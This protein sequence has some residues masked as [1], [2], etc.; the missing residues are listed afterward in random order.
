MTLHP[1]QRFI[2]GVAFTLIAASALA[3][4]TRVTGLVSD[5]ATGEPLPFV[6]VAFVDSRIAT[7][8]DID[9]QYAFDTYYATD[10]LRATSVG[11]LPLTRPVK[12]DAAQTIDFALETSR[13]EL[14]EVVVTYKENSAFAILRQVIRNKNV[15]N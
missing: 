15:N 8:T 12:R 4:T 7:T 10:S 2:P 14:P 3:Q 11:Y 9:G 13:A 5:A 1:T 6:S